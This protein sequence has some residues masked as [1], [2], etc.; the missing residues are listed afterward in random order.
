MQDRNRF[1]DYVGES[2]RQITERIKDHNG[3]DHTLQVWNYS[4]E[5]SL[6]NFSIIDFK[7]IDENF[8]KNKRKRK[9]AEAL[10][11]KDLR[12]TLNTQEKS[13]QLKLFN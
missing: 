11:I 8:H 10:W 4:I 6:K 2:A 3:R 1:Y 12:P 13:I 5:K 9:I 7:I